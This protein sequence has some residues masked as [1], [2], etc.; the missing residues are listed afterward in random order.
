M[1]FVSKGVVSAIIAYTTHYGIS[2]IYNHVCVP[3]GI[4][5]F[6]QGL[7]ATGSPVCQAGVQLIS[8]T[9]LSYSSLV[10]LGVSRLIV[11]WFSIK[12][13]TTG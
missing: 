8:S 4:L 12:D 2:K 3:D 5:G 11:D 1:E 13:Q 7:I 6:F 10:T 9:Q